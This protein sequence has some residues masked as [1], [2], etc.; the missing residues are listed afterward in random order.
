MVQEEDARLADAE[1]E[2]EEERRPE[3]WRM[4]GERRETALPP[5]VSTKSRELTG[6]FDSLRS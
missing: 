2:G 3:G 6:G 5:K 1:E 4:L